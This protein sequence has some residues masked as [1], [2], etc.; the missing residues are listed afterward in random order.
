VT[1]ATMVEMLPVEVRCSGVSIGYNICLGVFGGTA[2]LIAT[3]LVA[4]T[5]ADFAPVY[6][7][8]AIAIV[9]L[10]A[11]I[12]LHETARKPLL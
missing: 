10:V 11:L 5:A 12:G 2:P 7:L 8:M 3:Y 1:P 6:Y 9:S 4:R